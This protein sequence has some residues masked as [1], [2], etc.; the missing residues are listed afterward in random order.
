MEEEWRT[1]PDFPDYAVSNLGRVK[2]LTTS[3][4]GHPAGLILKPHQDKRIMRNGNIKGYCRVT[5]FDGEKTRT[6]PLHSLVLEVFV[7]DCP[8]GYECNHGDGDK[9][10]NSQNNL[11]WVTR[12]ENAAHAFKAGLREKMKGE[13]NGHHK[14]DDSQVREIIRLCASKEFAQARIAE[15]FGVSSATVSMI[16]H[17]KRWPHIGGTHGIG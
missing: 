11:E 17:G 10:R 9:G 6:V 2:R 5:L 3:R 4:R 8:P 1:I 14:V 13:R 15:R 12:S 7:S 16:K